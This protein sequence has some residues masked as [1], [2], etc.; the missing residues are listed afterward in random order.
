MLISRFWPQLQKVGDDFSSFNKQ[1]GYHSLVVA[2][3]EVNGR[4]ERPAARG[5]SAPPCY[6]HGGMLPA[7]LGLRRLS[8]DSANRSEHGREVRDASG[9]GVREAV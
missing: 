7:I 4:G 5:G 2:M 3:A 9:Q 8:L 1:S 6:A